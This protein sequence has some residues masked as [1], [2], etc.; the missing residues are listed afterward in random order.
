MTQHQTAATLWLDALC[1]PYN[2]H[3][4]EYDPTVEKLGIA[5]AQ[6][7]NADP[8]A[9]LKT[10]MVKVDGTPACVVLPVEY[11]MDFALVAQAFGGRKAKMMNRHDA[12]DY[13][14]YQI[15]GVSPFGQ[16]RPC[17]TAF[18]QRA[19]TEAH[20]QLI[21]NAGARGLL[22]SIAPENALAACTAITA[23]LSSS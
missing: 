13:T 15:G 17:R 11:E 6:A 8:Q 12:E 18:E 16:K 19:I 14:G 7:L 23:Q 22:L 4:Y 20:P 21:I 5:A 3:A 9:V 10:L 2:L 1:L